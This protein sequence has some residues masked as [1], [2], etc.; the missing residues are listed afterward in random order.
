M[1]M[2]I[3]V[4]VDSWVQQTL[5]ELCAKSYPIDDPI[6]NKLIYAASTPTEV[7]IIEPV[8]FEKLMLSQIENVKNILQVCIENLYSNETRSRLNACA[9][10]TR[11]FPYMCIKG[12][13]IGFE[14]FVIESMKVFDENVSPGAEIIST[15]IG[16]ISGLPLNDIDT[17][18]TELDGNV[19]MFDLLILIIFL[20]IEYSS[21]MTL[22]HQ[23]IMSASRSSPKIF[24]VLFHYIANGGRTISLIALLTLLMFHP[25]HEFTRLSSEFIKNGGVLCN[26]LLKI[27]NDES[28]VFCFLCSLAFKD[29][30]GPSLNTD[31]PDLLRLSFFKLLQNSSIPVEISQ[32]QTAYSKTNSRIASALLGRYEAVP[33]EVANTIPIIKDYIFEDPTKSDAFSSWVMKNL[34][35]MY[36]FQKSYLFKGTTLTFPKPNFEELDQFVT[37]SV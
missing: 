14:N 8:L 18:M 33:P 10:L 4:S 37:P 30:I 1:G 21:N 29:N 25:T 16:F 23:L 17:L 3:S 36:L 24:L 22:Y 32:I 15:S 31:N 9:I 35:N 27:K 34:P 13:P 20:L 7:F 19:A 26:Q 6:F 11:M 2:G 12:Y 28:D 5:E